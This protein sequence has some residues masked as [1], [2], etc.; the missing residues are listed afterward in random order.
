MAAVSYLKGAIML[1]QN[2]DKIP[3]D[4]MCLLN[5][6]MTLVDCDEF[7]KYMKIIY[8]TSKRNKHLTTYTFYLNTAEPEYTKYLPCR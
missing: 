1:L 5:N 3:T 2:C 8:F 6:V 4:T 7:T